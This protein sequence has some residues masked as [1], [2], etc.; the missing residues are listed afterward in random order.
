MWVW[1]LCLSD[2]L[3]WT[4][5]LTSFCSRRL[6]CTLIYVYFIHIYPELNIEKALKKMKFLLRAHLNVQ[7]F[8]SHPTFHSTPNWT[9]TSILTS[10]VFILLEMTNKE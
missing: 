7:H 10:P 3:L 6:L 1:I 9:A 4:E 5:F 2:L 8:L